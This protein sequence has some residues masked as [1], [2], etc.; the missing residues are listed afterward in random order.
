MK[1][2]VKPGVIIGEINARLFHACITVSSVFADY[3]VTAV[4]TSGRDGRHMPGSLHYEDLAWDFRLMNLPEKIRN[5]AVDKIRDI[6]NVKN[7]DYDV[8]IES[9]NGLEWLHIEYQPKNKTGV[10]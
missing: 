8:I 5:P 7:Q 6:L 1:V 3:G 4:L 10:S 9:A 2:I